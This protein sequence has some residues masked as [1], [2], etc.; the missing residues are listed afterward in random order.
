VATEV[1]PR[2]RFAN[3]FHAPSPDDVPN[4]VVPSE[5]LA[6]PLICNTE[7]GGEPAGLEGAKAI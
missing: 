5:L 1:I 2:I 3:Q 4:P 7:R 6:R